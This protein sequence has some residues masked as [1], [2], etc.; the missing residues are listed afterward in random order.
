MDFN[1]FRESA[2]DR[3]LAKKPE[4]DRPS[5]HISKNSNQ[6]RETR[7]S[8]LNLQLMEVWK[9]P[10]RLPAEG[11]LGSSENTSEPQRCL[12]F[13]ACFALFAYMPYVGNSETINLA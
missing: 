3:L 8:D 5:S 1:K 4:F 11:R 13:V 2:F 9:Q 12:F 6:P 7:M 10:G